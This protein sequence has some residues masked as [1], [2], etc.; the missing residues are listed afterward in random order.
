MGRIWMPG[1]GGG[2]DLDVV[3]AGANNVEAGKVIV[4]PDGE[5]LTGMLT[6]LSQNPDT[7]YADGNTTPVIKGDAAFVQSNM[8]GVK[9]ALIRYDGSSVRGKAIIQPNTL[10]GI[11]QADMATAGSLTAAKLAQGQSAFGLTGTYKGLGN[12]AAADVRKGKTF[13]T[14]SLSNATGTMAE[15]GAATYTPKTTAQT[16]AANQYLTG[17][18]TIAGDAN[19]V[20]GN[21]KKNV[22]IFGVKGTWEGYVANALDLYYRGSNPGGMAFYSGIASEYVN[23]LD[24]DRITIHYNTENTTGNT[25]YVAVASASLYNL[26]GYT[27]VAVRVSVNKNLS[28]SNTSFSLVAGNESMTLSAY[29]NPPANQKVFGSITIGASNANY[30]ANLTANTEYEFLIPFDYGAHSLTSRVGIKLRGFSKSY[31]KFMIHQIRLY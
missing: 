18:Q 9:R 19:L 23:S 24:T 16:I 26:T 10:I 4:G 12:A 1:G 6:N 17:V 21:I 20:A 3:T 5:P 27:G 29:G 2:A 13:S 28:S 14:A 8:D 30:T 11:P 31:T 22:T 15:K 7:Q 25:S